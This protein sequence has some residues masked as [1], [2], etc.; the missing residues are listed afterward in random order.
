MDNVNLLIRNYSTSDF[1]EVEALWM[2]T[3]WG[4]RKRRYAGSNRKNHKNGRK[5]FILENK[6]EMRSLEHPG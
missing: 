6:S 3:E 2:A 1:D 5:A 4:Q